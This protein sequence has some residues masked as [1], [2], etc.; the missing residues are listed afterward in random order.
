M[1]KSIDFCESKG[2]STRI[3][4]IILVIFEIID[5]HEFNKLNS[6]NDEQKATLYKTT[7]IARLFFA[8]LNLK[9]ILRQ[10]YL[11][12]THLP[13]GSVKSRGDLYR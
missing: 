13:F 3:C 5:C 4:K 9:F 12:Q 7:R 1:K 10:I 2:D 6:R 11:R 8:M